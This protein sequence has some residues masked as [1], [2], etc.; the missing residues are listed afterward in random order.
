MLGPRHLIVRRRRRL[1]ALCGRRR[2]AMGTKKPEGARRRRTS[3]AWRFRRLGGVCCES[4]GRLRTMFRSMSPVV[5]GEF[6]GSALLGAIG[7][8]LL[9]CSALAQTPGPATKPAEAPNASIQSTGNPG[10]AEPTPPAED[11]EVERKDL[12][13]Q[14]ALIDQKLAQLDA[15]RRARMG[16]TT[17]AGTTP[18]AAP[19]NPPPAAPSLAPGAEAAAAT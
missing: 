18:A 16:A 8:T 3:G 19:E 6:G 10:S 7:V 5:K 15:R 11:D 12:E 17:Q 9:S 13:R 2:A 14:R 1:W 4:R